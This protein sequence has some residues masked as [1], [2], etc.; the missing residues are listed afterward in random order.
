MVQGHHS[1][2]HRLSQFITFFPL[3]SSL[4]G[5]KPPVGLRGFVL[6]LLKYFF[7]FEYFKF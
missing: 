4:P 6:F 5:W 1:M 7:F 2:E 3:P